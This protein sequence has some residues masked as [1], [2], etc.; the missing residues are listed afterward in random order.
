VALLLNEVEWQR[1][2]LKIGEVCNS[3]VLLPHVLLEL[4]RAAVTFPFIVAASYNLAMMAYAVVNIEDVTVKVSRAGKCLVTTIHEAGDL[5]LQDGFLSAE[6]VMGEEFWVEEVGSVLCSSDEPLTHDMVGYDITLRSI[7]C[8][9]DVRVVCTGERSCCFC[10]K[11]VAGVLNGV[12]SN[13]AHIRERARIYEGT[14]LISD[15]SKRSVVVKEWRV[16]E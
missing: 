4:V 3:P 10:C 11:N 14:V 9:M 13:N 5:K 16:I 12:V 6:D 2:Y 8:R 15:K 7:M 1:G